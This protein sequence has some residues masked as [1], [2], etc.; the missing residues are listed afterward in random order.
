MLTSSHS[1]YSSLP[2]SPKRYGQGGDH[3]A[4]PA[5]HNSG[6]A[7]ASN[8]KHIPTSAS[9]A[10]PMYGLQDGPARDV[11]Y[12]TALDHGDGSS[13]S[14][15]ALYDSASSGVGGMHGMAANN[16][17]YAMAANDMV[18]NIP[19]RGDSFKTA[20]EHAADGTIY[21]IASN[22]GV[23]NGGGSSTE[24]G[25]PS[26]G[27]P[28]ISSCTRMG[29][30]RMCTNPAI[31]GTGFCVGHTCPVESCHAG[32]S[33]K[34]KDCGDHKGKKSSRNTQAYDTAGGANGARGGK[35]SGY[36]VAEVYDRQNDAEAAEAYRALQAASSV[37]GGA[38]QGIYDNNDDPNS[39]VYDTAAAGAVGTLGTG[40]G[41]GLRMTA[42][43]RDEYRGGGGES[44]GGGEQALYTLA[45]GAALDDSN[46][47]R[48]TVRHED[49]VGARN[50]A[51][52]QQLYA[53]ATMESS[54]APL[55][56]TAAAGG[57]GARRETAR[58]NRADYSASSG[59]TDIAHYDTGAGSGA[60]D[61]D[62]VY[63]NAVITVASRADD[64]GQPMYDTAGIVN[65]GSS[66]PV[67]DTGGS[68]GGNGGHGAPVY[69]AAAS[70]GEGDAVYDNAGQQISRGGRHRASG[71]YGFA[72][73]GSASDPARGGGRGGGGGI[74]RKQGSVYNGFEE[75]EDC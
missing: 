47:R 67:Y 8:P 36:N 44:G 37:Y 51:T 72:G 16:P 35:S 6:A 62:A 68:G 5:R 66:A 14:T 75:E 3:F 2:F 19:V 63:D 54:S 52:Q 64:G 1:I 59:G 31:P 18:Y 32:K 61:G 22:V 17:T 38:E 55:Y 69:A 46:Y 70:G 50:S 20:E 28:D 48:P 41:G 30:K 53:T 29:P 56:A 58:L 23:G 39:T 21:S 24:Y 15:D 33:S 73:G 11:L 42:Q 9:L 12:A 27:Y 7:A 65:D 71:E 26:G 45:N 13:S 57:G 60:G 10:N 40:G 74:G 25:A 49:M 34:A 4:Q 43:S